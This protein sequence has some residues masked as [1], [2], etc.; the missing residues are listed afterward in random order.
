MRTFQRICV[1]DYT[2]HDGE[3]QF[4]LQRGHEYTTSSVREEDGTVKVFSTYWVDVPVTIFAGVR[5]LQED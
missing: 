2:I 4:T 5:E 3:K 1:E